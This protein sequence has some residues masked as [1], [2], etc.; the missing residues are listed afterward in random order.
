MNSYPGFFLAQANS[1][2]TGAAPISL[3]DA[4]LVLCFGG[5]LVAA[6]QLNRVVH[7]ILALERRVNAARAPLALVLPPASP[8]GDNLPPHVVAAIVAACEEE[9]GGNAH[10]VSI[11]HGTDQKQMWS[12]EGRRQI[13]A[14]HQV[15]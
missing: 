2:A 4:L 12:H 15:R 11:A 9:L 8:A 6:Y 3:T 7:R 13:F 14:S 5:L 10:I 1:S